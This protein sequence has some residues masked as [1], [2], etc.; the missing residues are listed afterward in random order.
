MVKN[1]AKSNAILSV[2]E[3]QRI[4]KNQE[5][6]IKALKRKLAGGGDEPVEG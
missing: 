3:L 2:D 1:A 4:I 6:Q 5:A